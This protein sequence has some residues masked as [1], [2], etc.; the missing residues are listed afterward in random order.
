MEKV[1][2]FK[3]SLCVTENDGNVFEYQQKTIRTVM[4]EDLNKT[5]VCDK[6]VPRTLNNKQKSR[7]SA[8]CRDIISA[9]ENDPN[10]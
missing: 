6:F 5:K 9:A 10:L 1:I 7:R 4:H 2:Y 3:P 8:H